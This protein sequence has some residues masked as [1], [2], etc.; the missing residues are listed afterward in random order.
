MG[1]TYPTSQKVSTVQP[2]NNCKTTHIVYILHSS[3]CSAFYVCYTK[4]CLPDKVAEH[5]SEGRRNDL[6]S[7]VVVA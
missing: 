3:F 2:F 7:A 5:L 4:W 1:F 6:V